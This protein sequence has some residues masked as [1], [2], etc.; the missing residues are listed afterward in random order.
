MK[1]DECKYLLIH[2]L[3]VNRL[4]LTTEKPEIQTVTVQ[5]SK[6]KCQKSVASYK[7]TF[8]TLDLHYEFQNQNYGIESSS[9]SS[10]SDN[11]LLCKSSNEIRKGKDLTL[12]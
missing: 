12:E 5:T 10:D 9:D 6:P 1:A 11:R 3:S 2:F 7:T 8:N 4:F